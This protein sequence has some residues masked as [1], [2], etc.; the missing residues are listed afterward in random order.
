MS[1][2]QP[3]ANYEILARVG[4]GAMGTVFKA[5]QKHLERT[6]ALKVLK[7]ALA[8]D[9]RYVERL[10]REARIVAKLNHQNIVT[11]YDLGHEAGYHYFVMEFVEG[12]SLR[13][14]LAEW[15]AFPERQVLDVAIQVADAL[16][17]AFDCGIIHRDIKPGNILIDQDGRAKL[18]DMGLAKAET[19]LALTRDGATV[20][21]PQYIAPEQAT[22]PQAAD[23]R[24]DLYSLGATLFHM[25]TGQPPFRAD[26]IGELIAKVLHERPPSVVDLV[27][28]I[29]DGLSLV[30][31]KLLAKDPA[32][33]YQTPRELLEDLH[34]VE[35]RERPRIGREELEAQD[36]AVARVPHRRQRVPRNLVGA[37]ILLVTFASG[38]VLGRLVVGDVTGAPTRDRVATVVAEL[39]E[40]PRD[41]DRFA[42]LQQRAAAGGDL[43]DL[44]AGAVRAALLAELERRQLATIGAVATTRRAEVERYLVSADGWREPDFVRTQLV[45]ELEAGTGYRPENLPDAAL[46]RTVRERLA[47]LRVELDA[48]RVARDA[49]LC[50]RFDRFLTVD[51]EPKA[52]AIA[53]RGDPALALATFAR[54]TERFFAGESRPDPAVLASDVQT[55]I[56]DA[57]TGAEQRLATRVHEVQASLARDA[58]AVF[59]QRRAEFERLRADPAGGTATVERLRT[60]LRGIAAALRHE[61]PPP[62]AF[63]DGGDTP[64]PEIER[65]L[66]AANAELEVRAAAAAELVLGQALDLAYAVLGDGGP[67]AARR[68]LEVAGGDGAPSSGAREQHLAIFAAAEE[69][70]AAL[71]DAILGPR[72]TAAVQIEGAGL[73]WTREAGGGVVITRAQDGAVVAFRA[74]DLEAAIGLSIVPEEVLARASTDG[75]TRLARACALALRLAPARAVA[76]LEG[77][78]LAL[79]QRECWPRLQ[80]SAA[81]ADA[82]ERAAQQALDELFTLRRSG[83]ALAL[84]DALLGFER[85]HAGTHAFAK[86]AEFRASLAHW[87]EARAA[88][89][90]REAALRARAPAG[91]TVEV[92]DDRVERV[93]G[94]AGDLPI[95]SFAGAWSCSD[96]VAAAVATQ[97]QPGTDVA[98]T[99]SLASPFEADAEDVAC[100]V[101][102]RLDDA[103]RESRVAVVE[104][105]GVAFVIAVLPGGEV[106]AT[107]VPVHDLAQRR[108]EIRRALAEPLL[109]ADP[110]ALAI[111]AGVW[112]RVRCTVRRDGGG[113]TAR[114]DLDGALRS[115]LCE[116]RLP[117]LEVREPRFG[118]GAAQSIAVREIVVLRRRP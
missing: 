10:E 21:T 72:S 86:T 69:L 13:Q 52:L 77:D 102:L 80:A 31:R 4:S 42:R 107:A 47:E 37:A 28:E 60:A 63:A 40:L 110:R 117:A 8:R 15:G 41:I 91:F 89:A 104:L 84:R 74:L 103:D 99:C 33:R 114:C 100:E 83:D 53:Q 90:E 88:G 7:P 1:F 109:S 85:D 51:L 14:L 34:R 54:E 115:P 48:L 36:D 111:V 12:R 105:H 65:W 76:L 18:T 19:D 20:G 27:P 43:D 93:A 95:A 25:A 70:S 49:A 67:A 30:I 46:G 17:H 16:A 35:R 98:I 26:A 92:D 55:R 38:I 78:D 79:F 59:A 58:R 2:A 97:Q 56:D 94:R 62:A 71:A 57:R 6:V 3:F 81:V 116:V 75:P 106:A 87:A 68:V 61:V 29:S 96:G 11:A 101:E 50:D 66:G 5:R 23:I 118:V 22:N 39:L 9:A 24:S 73:V 44:L 113:P 32:L 82:A 112:H 108:D 45:P 64:W